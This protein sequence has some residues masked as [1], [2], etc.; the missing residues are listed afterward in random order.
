MPSLRPLRAIKWSPAL[1]FGHTA[2]DDLAPGAGGGPPAPGSI[3]PA[4]LDRPYVE[5]T[6]GAGA[7]GILRR[8]IRMWVQDDKVFG[9]SEDEF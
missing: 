6:F 4:Q 3:T 8:I 5:S 7:G 2:A 1:L 9:E